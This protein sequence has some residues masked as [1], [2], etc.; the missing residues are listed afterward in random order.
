MNGFKTIKTNF[1]SSQRSKYIIN[2]KE[3]L[4]FQTKSIKKPFKHESLLLKLI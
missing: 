3:S 2:I 4:R 1:D